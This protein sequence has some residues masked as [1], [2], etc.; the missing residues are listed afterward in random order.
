MRVSYNGGI[1][2]FIAG[3]FIHVYFMEHR[4]EVDDLGVS[5]FWETSIYIHIYIH[6]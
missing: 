5:L 4:I 1:Y 6:T 2:P 3:W